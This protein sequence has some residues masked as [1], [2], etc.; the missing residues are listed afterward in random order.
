MLLYALSDMVNTVL[1]I[2]DDIRLLVS[3]SL[4]VEL[5]QKHTVAHLYTELL[6][7]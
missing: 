7:K 6:Q 4:N 5:R 1:N 2:P 3:E